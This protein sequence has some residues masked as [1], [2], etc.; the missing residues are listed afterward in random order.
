MRQLILKKQL[1]DIEKTLP[2]VSSRY[3]RINFD[4]LF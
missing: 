1:E 2:V 4:S 3:K